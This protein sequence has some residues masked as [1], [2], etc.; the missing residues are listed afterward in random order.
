MKKQKYY[1]QNSRVAQP[2]GD[3]NSRAAAPPSAAPESDGRFV[4]CHPFRVNEELL[5][6]Q[7]VNSSS[8]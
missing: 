5:K 1:E 7:S 8:M 3:L 4:F 2:L 6:N